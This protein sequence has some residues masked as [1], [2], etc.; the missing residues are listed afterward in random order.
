MQT[1]LQQAAKRHRIIVQALTL[2]SISMNLAN[3]VIQMLSM[4]LFAHVLHTKDPDEL[5]VWGFLAVIYLPVTFLVTLAWLLVIA[6]LWLSSTVSAS[7]VLIKSVFGRI[8][9]KSR[10]QIS[11]VPL[12]VA[13]LLVSLIQVA[14]VIILIPPASV[15]NAL[16]ASFIMLAINITTLPVFVY[17]LL[18]APRNS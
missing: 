8:S 6:G 13:L 3:G 7:T 16:K 15:D 11:I 1:D 9:R 14:P 5:S 10:R 17:P 4:A 18:R 2:C 12:D